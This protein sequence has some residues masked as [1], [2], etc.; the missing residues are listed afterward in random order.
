M[1]VQAAHSI[2]PQSN[3][4]E[5]GQLS[6]DLIIQEP[7]YKKVIPARMLRRMSKILKMGVFSGLR[8]LELAGIEEPDAIITATGL[9]SLADTVK[10]L[11]QIEEQT[12]SMLSPTPFIQSTH[13]TVGGQIAL[14]LK[15]NA[16][17]MT[18]VQQHLSFE[19][20]LLDASLLLKESPDQNILLGGV[21]ERHEIL[22]HAYN[23]LSNATG[24]ALLHPV[25]EGASFFMFTGVPGEHSKAHVLH[26][27]M[28]KLDSD[29]AKNL[30]SIICDHEVS[31][32]LK[33][34]MLATDNEFYEA[35]QLPM[36]SL[37]YKQYCGEYFTCSGFALYLATQMLNNTV[38]IN[39]YSG[40]SIAILNKF[41]D[42]VGL[43]ILSKVEL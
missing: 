31:F 8:T 3:S 10:F 42:N 15:S 28:V 38:V 21:D 20:A 6:P 36:R 11:D 39:D 17:N 30:K 35:L 43:T 4:I 29:S 5:T 25:T 33:G 18:F 9:G 41:L 1:Y 16:Y 37:D 34:S 7:D 22:N 13:N 27:S 19:C 40:G 24:K 23:E 32:M 26:T 12:D 14:A 2:S